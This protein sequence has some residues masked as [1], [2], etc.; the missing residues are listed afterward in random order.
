MARRRRQSGFCSEGAGFMVWL[1]HGSFLDLGQVM[2]QQRLP[3]DAI[4][5]APFRGRT[6]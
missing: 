4:P 2:R 6:T 3:A 1:R 5:L